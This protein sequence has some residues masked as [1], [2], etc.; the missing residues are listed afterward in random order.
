MRDV[1]FCTDAFADAR[2]IEYSER[3][4]A[5][6]LWA[7]VFADEAHLLVHPETP[8]LYQAGVYWE[9]EKPTGKSPCEGGTGQEQFLGIRQ[10]IAQGKADCEDLAC[11]RVAEVRLGRGERRGI[12]PRK[13]HPPVTPCPVPYPMRPKGPGV[14]PGFF[15]RLISKN[16]LLYHI[17]VVYPNGRIEDPS[18]RLGMGGLG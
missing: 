4:L 2:T 12:A 1:T 5:C 3:H 7:L 16:T 14:V 17:V 10:V 13:G 6:L 9:A 11:W 18:R 8:A 15:K